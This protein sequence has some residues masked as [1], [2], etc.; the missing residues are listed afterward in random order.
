[1]PDIAAINPYFAIFELLMWGLFAFCWRHSRGKGTLARWI[2]VAGVVFG[3][4]L[5]RATLWQLHAYRYG[6]FFVMFGDVP[7][8]IGMGWGVIIC[9]VQEVADA[10]S[11]PFW[12]RP[13]LAG[14]LALNIDLSMDAIAIRLGMWRWGFPMDKDFFGVPYAN[15]WAWFWVV[16]S[17]TFAVELVT[18]RRLTSSGVVASLMA[19]AFGLVGVLVTNEFIVH[20]VPRPAARPVIFATLGTALAIVAMLHPKFDG[21]TMSPTSFVVPAAFHLYFL[22]TGLVSGVIFRPAGILVVGTTMLALSLWLH[23]PALRR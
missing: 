12:A 14:L 16:F 20:V 11:L 10:T 5:E 1:M 21:G 23:V 22:A 6:R 9:S 17:F 7:L 13:L 15:F 3:L 2:L 19:I 8:A 18:E 4:M